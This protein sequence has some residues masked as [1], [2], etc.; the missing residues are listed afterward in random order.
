LTEQVELERRSFLTSEIQRSELENE[1]E[2]LTFQ[3][4]ALVK[5]N[6]E[7]SEVDATTD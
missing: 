2:A 5:I 6:S 3:I 1:N 7:D 4:R